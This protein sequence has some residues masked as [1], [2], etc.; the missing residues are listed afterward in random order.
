MIFKKDRLIDIQ[1]RYIDIYFI[2]KKMPVDSEAPVVPVVHVVLE[3]GGVL[4]KLIDIKQLKSG[5]KCHF[6]LD[7]G[8]TRTHQICDNTTI[9]KENGCL[10]F[11]YYGKHLITAKENTVFVEYCGE[12]R[13]QEVLGIGQGTMCGNILG[14]LDEDDDVNP[15]PDPDPDPDAN[16]RRSIEY[17]KYVRKYAKAIQEV[18]SFI[19]KECKITFSNRKKVCFNIL[20][21]GNS[22]NIFTDFKKV[23]IGKDR[24]GVYYCIYPEFVSSINAP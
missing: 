8:M 5:D 4:R 6:I 18:E 14:D 11:L 17:N 24:D 15:D 10:I 9:K 7:D 12:R 23:I 21:I 22:P 13:Y 3:F 20:Y 19:G 16:A 1:R 2:S